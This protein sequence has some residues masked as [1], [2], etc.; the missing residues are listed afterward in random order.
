MGKHKNIKNDKSNLSVQLFEN[1][2][3]TKKKNFL[4]INRDSQKKIIKKYTQQPKEAKHNKAES[5]KHLG[6]I[7]KCLFITHKNFL[8]FKEYTVYNFHGIL[9]GIRVNFH[10]IL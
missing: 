4:L 5:K 8:P 10:K 2:G 6:F 3:S 1:H 9:Y 7:H